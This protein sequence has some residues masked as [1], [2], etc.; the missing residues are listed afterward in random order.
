MPINKT[1]LYP[2][3][4]KSLRRSERLGDLAT[5]K[6]LDLPLDDDMQIITNHTRS[7]LGMTGTLLVSVA[8]LISG[9]AGGVALMNAW[10]SGEAASGN[11]DPQA[12]SP[13]PVAQEFKVSFW[14]ED[15]EHLE[16]HGDE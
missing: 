7:G 12:A 2:M 10:P 1:Q 3:F 13:P 16:V 6:A 9:S 8:M 14:T 5:R 11:V 4:E 15:G